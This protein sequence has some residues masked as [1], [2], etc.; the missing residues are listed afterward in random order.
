MMPS[1]SSRRRSPHPPPRAEDG[2]VA[3]E[4]AAG[5]PLLVLAGMC[6]IQVGLLFAG[7]LGADGAARAVARADA[8]GENVRLAAETSL[9]AW[10]EDDLEVNARG[11]GRT[12]LRL[13]VP[14]VVPLVLD[15]FDVRRVVYFAPPVREG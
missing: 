5:V 13:T 6:V 10:L 14:S 9:P 15:P 7:I 8:R 11:A 4:F 1:T 2:S 12:E 3:L